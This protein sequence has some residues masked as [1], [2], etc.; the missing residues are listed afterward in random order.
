M[1]HLKPRAFTLLE[2]IIVMLLISFLVTVI[3]AAFLNVYTYHGRLSRKME[4]SR[5]LSSLRASLERDF[6]KT[7]HYEIGG[8]QLLFTSERDSISYYFGEAI[9]RIQS[10]RSDTFP[11]VGA[12]F[13]HDSTASISIVKNNS[14]IKLKLPDRST[15]LDRY[16]EDLN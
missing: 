13:D 15:G 7:K 14:L 1:K 2:L 8:S 10:I 6:N 4:N 5:E 11:F 16:Q 3:G 12:I 9:V